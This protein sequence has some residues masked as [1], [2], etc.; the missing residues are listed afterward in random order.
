MLKYKLLLIVGI[1]WL[2]NSC[3]KFVTIDLPK[4][5]LT[6][7]IVFT[8]SADADAAVRGIYV[9]FM[10]SYGISFFSGSIT[11]DAGMSAD[12]LIQS[13]TDEKTEYFN[14]ALSVENSTNATFW[15]SGFFKLYNINACLEG[16][17]KSS[18]LKE[19]DKKNLIGEIKT[20]RAMVLFNLVNLYGAIP[21]PIST[22]YDINR[23][24]SNTP[25]KLVYEK[26]I[27]DLKSAKSLLPKT[28][29][30]KTRANYYAA[31]SLLARLYLYTKNYDL[32]MQEASEVINSHKYTLENN[33]DSV[34]LEESREVILAFQSVFPGVDT[35]EGK[36]FVPS[37]AFQI[38]KYT[39]ND[40]LL[41]SFAKNDK[42]IAQWIKIITVNN[43]DY[44]IPY[45]YH[46]YIDNAERHETYV[47]LRLAELYLI[48]S[49]AEVKLGDLENAK[50]DLN[51]I[52]QR[53]GLDPIESNNADK[54]FADI[55]N[56]RRWEL[57][58]EWGHRWFDLVR[59]GRVMEV[60]NQH[61]STYSYDEMQVGINSSIQEHEL[62]FPIPNSQ[63]LLNPD[64]LHQNPG[65]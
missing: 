5:E 25:V 47:V 60:M 33:L 4:N 61:F 26:I 14:N 36:E 40:A 57:M 38:P 22:D 52:R 30:N 55:Q 3:K 58:F 16:I 31:T 23:L 15:R 53:A 27:E 32:A 21:L 37:F 6:T 59:T 9:N 2:G 34:F 35:W 19:S 7:S 41:S 18:T 49:E 42:R 8:D 13:V 12:E 62:I 51:I 11:V 24:L 48:K 64:K 17:N 65:Y 10:Q 28:A 29:D 50:T 46:N 1:I 43:L 54:L 63:I 44:S 20:I 45:K 56:E 39:V